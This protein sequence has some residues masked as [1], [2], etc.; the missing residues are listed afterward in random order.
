MLGVLPGGP[1]LVAFG[2]VE[3]TPW[4]D[5][6]YEAALWVSAD[7]LT[8]ERVDAAGLGV[9][10]Q[11]PDGPVALGFGPG[12]FLGDRFGGCERGITEPTAATS[13]DGLTWAAVPQDIEEF[14][15]SDRIS[16]TVSIEAVAAAGDGF[17]A[18]GWEM[19]TTQNALV[20]VSDDGTAWTRVEDASLVAGD[21]DGN[22][23][24]LT[25]VTAGGPGLIAV[26]NTG[27]ADCFDCRRPAV[28]VSEDGLSWQRLGENALDIAAVET[29]YNGFYRVVADPQTG[30]L[31][32]LAPGWGFWASADGLQWHHVTAAAPGTPLGVAFTP[33]RL[34]AVGVGADNAQVW[35]SAD[36]GASWGL[37]DHGN[38][39]FADAS[40]GGGTVMSAV[41][42]FGSTFVA[43]GSEGG[44]AGM[45]AAVWIGTWDE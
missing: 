41:T 44:P 28:W 2:G 11:G 18:V 13:A 39:R 9:V 14:C 22:H 31:F 15:P 27:V 16:Q 30:A 34:V 5:L 33:E 45:H 4:P 42:V 40:E 23:L 32:A 6:T 19:S 21:G 7:G 10:A 17:V 8:W 3:A 43:V 20:W 38:P 24:A 37:V 29:S 35:A 12:G 1:G 36:G 26:G 25:G